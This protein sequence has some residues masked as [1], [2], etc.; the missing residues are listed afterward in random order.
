MNDRKI[1]KFSHCELLFCRHTLSILL[2]KST[3]AWAEFLVLQRPLIQGLANDF[4][5]LRLWQ[6]FCV[7]Q[8]SFVFK[9]LLWLW[10]S[11]REKKGNLTWKIFH[12][13]TFHLKLV[14]WFH[15]IFF[16]VEIGGGNNFLIVEKW[17]FAYNY[18]VIFLH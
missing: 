9:L 2:A 1:L 11:Y 13:K 18:R 7:I 14:H 15:V 16:L 10:R 5:N 6:N 3:K 12:E 17:K 8:R 4:T